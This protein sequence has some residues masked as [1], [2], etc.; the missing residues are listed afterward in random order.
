MLNRREKAGHDESRGCRLKVDPKKVEMHWATIVR[1]QAALGYDA[2]MVP[3]A[4]MSKASAIKLAIEIERS[5]FMAGDSYLFG[6]DNPHLKL[7]EKV[8]LDG[9]GVRH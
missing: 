5:L 1:E 4:C 2:I 8:N 3:M 7:G 6:K 9:D